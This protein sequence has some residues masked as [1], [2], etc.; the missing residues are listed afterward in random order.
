MKS[1]SPFPERRRRSSM[2]RAVSRCDLT[3]TVSF[4]KEPAPAQ[5]GRRMRFLRPA[6]GSGRARDDRPSSG[7]STSSR[8]CWKLHRVWSDGPA[9]SIA[10]SDASEHRW[11]PGSAAGLRWS[12]S[13]GWTTAEQRRCCA[14]AAA[15]GAVVQAETTDLKI[16]NVMCHSQQRIQQDH[17][18]LH[19][20]LL[21]A[22]P[23]TSVGSPTY[24]R[25]TPTTNQRR[26]KLSG[27]RSTRSLGL[28]NRW[29]LHIRTNSRVV[30]INPAT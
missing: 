30:H 3:A 5:S 25:L 11:R 2:W 22:C 12:G 20:A 13:R 28:A 16:K 1:H 17:R 15:E 4:V 14:S 24:S 9:I 8:G 7:M 10:Q 19:A 29:R 6:G 18:V 27:D 21:G 26:T 23:P